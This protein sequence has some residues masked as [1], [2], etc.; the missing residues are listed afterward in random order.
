MEKS[1]SIAAAIKECFEYNKNV[2]QIHVTSDGQ[3]FLAGAKSAADLHARRNKLT[4]TTVNRDEVDEKKPSEGYDAK[5]VKEL[6][7]IITDERKLD[8]PKGSKKQALIDILTKD[9][10]RI[11]EEQKLADE[12][13]EDEDLGAVNVNEEEEI[14][15]EDEDEEN[16]TK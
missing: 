2:D 3:C 6:S 5:S 13:I 4:V 10:E 14:E 8:I 1:K 15:D 16:E 9:D 12:S 7:A 11:A